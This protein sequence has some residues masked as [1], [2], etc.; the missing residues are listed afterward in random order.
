M[1]FSIQVTRVMNTYTFDI[2]KLAQLDE[3]V[4]WLVKR[5][6]APSWVYLIGDLGAGKTTFAQRFI[7]CKGYNGRVSSPT[8]ALM[9]EYETMTGN[10]IH[11]DLYRLADPLELYEIG[12]LEAV[13]DNRAIALVEWPTKG[14]G[15]LPPAN[16]TLH[17]DWQIQRRTLQVMAD[18]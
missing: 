15:V 17:F 12:L 16:V 7:A 4:L 3:V 5:I 11:C 6:T 2:S 18:F 10:V 1:D 8:Y 13:I 14:Q 9:Q